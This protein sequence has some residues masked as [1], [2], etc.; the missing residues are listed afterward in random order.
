[1]CVCACVCVCIYR[2]CVYIPCVCV[3]ACQYQTGF[4]K[5]NVC[6]PFH[7]KSFRSS[8]HVCQNG[9]LSSSA[10]LGLKFSL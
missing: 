2:M 3:F 1:M 9:R 10:M 7:N 6:I 5:F 4:N 8:V